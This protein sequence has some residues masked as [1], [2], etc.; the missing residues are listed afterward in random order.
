MTV[1]IAK[2]ADKMR[3]SKTHGYGCRK[4]HRGAGS[5]GGHGYAGSHKHKWT[6]IVKEEPDHFG[7]KGFHRPVESINSAI[8]INIC[9]LEMFK[10]EE[11]N[12][13]ELGFDKLLGKGSLSRKVNVR[14]ASFTEKAKDKIEKAGGK[15]I[16]EQAQ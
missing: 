14:V 6:K 1:R 8:T 13:S 12:L 10:D 3:G 15:I 9:D 4:K 2:K 7:K 11:I 16:T 5:K